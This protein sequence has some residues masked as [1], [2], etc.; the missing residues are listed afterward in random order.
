MSR[1]I[2]TPTRPFKP[3]VSF[4]L[5]GDETIAGGAGG[6]ESL[7]RPR[8][9]PATAW[10]S[11]PARTLEL[12]LLLEGREYTG[13]GVDRV[14]ESMCRQVA[15]WGLPTNK[16]DEPPVL[17]VDGL[18]RV[19]SA[20][21]WVVQDI[22]WGPYLVNDAGQR[23]MQSI[24]LVLLEYA[25]AELVESRAKRARKRRRSRDD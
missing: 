13:V 22:T 18:V 9:R 20:L 7:D 16:T 2:I 8:N 25:R 14:V 11:T 1:V 24:G 17:R 15:L 19:D 3:G 12:P 21:R 10:V 6:W 23:V 5:D 4:E